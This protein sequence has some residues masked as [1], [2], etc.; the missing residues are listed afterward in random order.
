V[1]HDRGYQV[2]WP[3]DRNIIKNFVGYVEYVTFV[4]VDFNCQHAWQKCFQMHCNQIIDLAFT[5]PGANQFNTDSYLIQDKYSFDEYKYQ[6][7]NVPFEEKWKLDIKR[8]HEMELRVKLSLNSDDYGLVQYQ[9]SDYTRQLSQDCFQDKSG[10]DVINIG[11]KTDSVLDWILALE[12]AK[13]HVLIESCF[14]NLVDQLNITVPNQTLLL[15]NGY[16]G[17]TLQDGRLKGIPV[18]RNDWKRI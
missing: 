15:K 6:I 4:E 12:S 13:E 8:N 14:S 11:N 17:A 9:S 7:A 18:L 5:L 2:I 1:Y 3:L 10:L 16:Y